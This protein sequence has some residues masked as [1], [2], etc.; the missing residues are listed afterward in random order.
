[1]PVGSTS[2]RWLS[3]AVWE[4]ANGRS[5]WVDGYNRSSLP[6]GVVEVAAAGPCP[7]RPAERPARAGG[8]PAAGVVCPPGRRAA[9]RPHWVVEDGGERGPFGCATVLF[10]GETL[11]ARP[12]PPD[13]REEGAVSRQ[14]PSACGLSESGPGRGC[15][16]AVSAQ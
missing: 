15:R 3:G 4:A 8:S 11:S 12:P 1:V 14:L 6:S 10:A 7:A 16:R 5:G 9:R 2:W 13:G